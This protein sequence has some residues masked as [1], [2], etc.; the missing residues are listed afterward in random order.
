MVRPAETVDEPDPAATVF[1]EILKLVGV[2]LVLQMNGDHACMMPCDGSDFVSR[3]RGS[4]G[5]GEVV[6]SDVADTGA[7]QRMSASPDVEADQV[8]RDSGEDV[9]EVGSIAGRG[10]GRVSC[11]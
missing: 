4:H 11:R 10:R 3:P 6:S 1:F 5:E 7:V 2:D 8:T 9:L